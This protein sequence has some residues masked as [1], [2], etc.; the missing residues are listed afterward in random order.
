MEVKFEEYSINTD[1]SL[2]NYETIHRLVRK[3]DFSRFCRIHR[4]DCHYW[5]YIEVFE[6][7]TL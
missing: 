3:F 7:V 2:L 6:S 1:K 4:Y 5:L